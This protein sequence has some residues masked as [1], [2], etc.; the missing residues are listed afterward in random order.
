MR[1]N[2]STCIKYVFVKL[3]GEEEEEVDRV[4]VVVVVMET[5]MENENLGTAM[6]KM[7]MTMV[8]LTMITTDQ[9]NNRGLERNHCTHKNIKVYLF[10][11]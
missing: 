9:E 2:T 5:V 8:T 7:K 10:K 3:L 1:G 6:L 11:F 4:V